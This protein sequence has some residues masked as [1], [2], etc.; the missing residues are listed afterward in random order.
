M[1]NM[2]GELNT[3][4]HWYALHTQS[5]HE[6]KVDSQLK[7]KGI[8]SYLPLNTV[9]RR[10]SDRYKK[11]QAPLFSCYVFVNIALKDRLHV[12]QTAGAV[13]LVSFNGKPA[14]IPDEQ[15]YAV[16]MILEN[17]ATVNYENFFTPGV[18]VRILRGAL[19]G[20]EG[21]L[22]SNKNNNRL[23]ISID[24]IKQAISVEIDPKDLELIA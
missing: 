3:I 7:A 23:I 2:W 24:G 16:R 10:W 14:L 12:L 17:V 22:V 4:N 5:R 21:T 8:N 6:K 9:H 13:N 1:N 18:R 20:L 19:K 15:I 11:I